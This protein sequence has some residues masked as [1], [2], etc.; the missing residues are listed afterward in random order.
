MP[1]LAGRGRRGERVVVLTDAVE[2]ERPYLV[3]FSFR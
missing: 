2:K 1:D 3:D